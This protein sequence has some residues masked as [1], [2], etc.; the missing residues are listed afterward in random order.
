MFN[1]DFWHGYPPAEACWFF[2][3]NKLGH[4]VTTVRN[5][6]LTWSLE[7]EKKVFLVNAYFSHRKKRLLP[8]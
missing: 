3:A 4:I 8:Q 2:S 1:A 7:L 5:K 6:V